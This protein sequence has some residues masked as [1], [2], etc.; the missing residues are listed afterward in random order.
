MLPLWK[1]PDSG[2][3]SS[4]RSGLALRCSGGVWRGGLTASGFASNTG[5]SATGFSLCSL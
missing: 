4:S 2:A 3:S 5:F 1:P